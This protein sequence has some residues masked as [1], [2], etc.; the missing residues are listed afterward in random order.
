MNPYVQKKAGAGQRVVN[1]VLIALAALACVGVAAVG[2]ADRNA[3][4]AVYNGILGDNEKVTFSQ[5]LSPSHILVPSAFAG[6]VSCSDGVVNLKN[7]GSTNFSTPSVSY[8]RGYSPVLS[9][10]RFYLF[11]YDVVGFTTGDEEVSL[12]VGVYDDA[13]VFKNVVDVMP[14]GAKPNVWQQRFVDVFPAVGRFG[15]RDLFCKASSS[16]AIRNLMLVDVTSLGLLSE[17]QS[18]ERCAVW[19]KLAG[20]EYFEGDKAF[21]KGEIRKAVADYEAEQAAP[22]SGSAA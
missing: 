12:S 1:G 8:D 2:V 21:T 9:P 10:S 18:K 14:E 16:G 15:L 11:S 13:S 5:S 17:V 3:I 6:V 4:S 7:A 19:G 22:K 20:T